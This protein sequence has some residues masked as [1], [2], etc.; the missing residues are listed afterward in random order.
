MEKEGGRES[1]FGR[2]EE[3]EKEKEEEKKKKKKE[4]DLFKESCVKEVDSGTARQGE[5]ERERERVT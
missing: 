3:K 4:D 2:E 5:R 1:L